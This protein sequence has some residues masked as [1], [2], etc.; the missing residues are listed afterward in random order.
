[1]KVVHADS[2][3]D[4]SMPI[5]GKHIFTECGR[6]FQDSFVPNKKRFTKDF[7]LV[8]CKICN[9]IIKLRGN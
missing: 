3:H 1:M 4:F 8:T 2:N 6:T 7:S 9:K 5:S